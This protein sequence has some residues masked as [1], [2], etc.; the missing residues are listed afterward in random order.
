MRP[1]YIS[2]QP[3]PPT[4]LRPQLVHFRNSSLE[5]LILA[6]LVGMSLIL[7]HNRPWVSYRE[8]KHHDAPDG[9]EVYVFR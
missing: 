2:I 7:H 5:L 4:L 3:A 8:G 9:K 1:A 6:L